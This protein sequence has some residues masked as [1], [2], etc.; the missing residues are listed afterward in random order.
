MLASYPRVWT[1]RENSRV[2]DRVHRRSRRL[3]QRHRLQGT[4]SRMGSNS[5]AARLVDRP[6]RETN[7]PMPERTCA[8]ESMRNP[9]RVTADARTPARSHVSMRNT[10]TCSVDLEKTQ[11]LLS[12]IGVRVSAEHFRRLRTG[13]GI[14]AGIVSGPSIQE[15]KPTHT[16]SVCAVSAAFHDGRAIEHAN[17]NKSR[18]IRD[19]RRTG[20]RHGWSTSHGP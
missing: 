10:S 12:R 20:P 3:D 7:V 8:Q 14:V 9:N 13:N 11:R 5:S 6:I 19:R 4:C 2:A 1:R 15:P 18:K 16:L 17:S